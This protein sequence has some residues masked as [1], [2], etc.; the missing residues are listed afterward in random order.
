MLKVA[1]VY[2]LIGFGIIAVIMVLIRVKTIYNTIGKMIEDTLKDRE[3]K[4]SMPR[5]MMISAF[6]ACVV[7]FFY[8][9]YKAGHMNEVAFVALL[10]VAVTGKI[11]DAQAKKIDPTIVAPLEKSTDDEKK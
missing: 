3:G 6:N 1:I 2:T 10:T 8:D 5:I 4:W 7:A 11:A 9:M